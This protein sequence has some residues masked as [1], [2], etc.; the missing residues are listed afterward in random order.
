MM[1]ALEW[2]DGAILARYN[3]C[4]SGSGCPPM[5]L[6]LATCVYKQT[7]GDANITLGNKK[8][9][10][11]CPQCNNTGTCGETDYDPTNITLCTD[12][13]RALP[14]CNHYNVGAQYHIVL[15][16]EVFHVCGVDHQGQNNGDLKCNSLMACCMLRAFGLLGRGVNCQPDMTQHPG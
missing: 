5:T 11:G 10:I 2:G 8:G 13:L 1:Q 12:K 15:L 16:H 14:Y 6:D 3:A 4:V 7:C 9:G